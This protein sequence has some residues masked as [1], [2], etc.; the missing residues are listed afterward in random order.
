[1]KAKIKAPILILLLLL[2]NL[3]LAAEPVSKSLFGGVAIGG[4]DTVAY[5]QQNPDQHRA[6]KGSKSY[7]V[8]WK[9]A[10]WRFATK[11]DRETFA[12][13]PEK[14]SPAYNGF[15]ANA[16]SLG[17]GLLKTDGSYWQIFDDQLFLFYAQPG[18]D[19]WSGGDYTEYKKL[20]DR[21]WQDILVREE[22]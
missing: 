7:V 19:R 20:A 5:H 12:A 3:V 8:E 18:E 4:S 6:T 22:N 2:S 11:A 9:G 16:L 1:M 17:N 14:Y 21:A 13:N 10:K 15:C